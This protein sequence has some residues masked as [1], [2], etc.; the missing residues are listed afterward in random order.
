MTES[1]EPRGFMIGACLRCGSIYYP[2][3]DDLVRAVVMSGPFVRVCAPCRLM[4]CLPPIK[5]PVDAPEN[6]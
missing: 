6:P 1:P 5:E 4:L 3:D 2:P